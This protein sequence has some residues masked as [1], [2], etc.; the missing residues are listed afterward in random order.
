MGRYKGEEYDIIIG[1][2]ANDT[3]YLTFTGY[4]AGATSREDAIRQ[5]KVRN[6]YSQVMFCNEKS[7]AYLT[8][9]ETK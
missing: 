2:V 3:V 9:K 5:L 7:L 4:L 6:L 1:P 8:F